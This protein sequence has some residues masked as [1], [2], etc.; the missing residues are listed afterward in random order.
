MERKELSKKV[1]LLSYCNFSN[2]VFI[3]GSLP[4]L[5][6]VNMFGEA[7]LR[8]S[9]APYNRSAKPNRYHHQS[10]SLPSLLPDPRYDNSNTSCPILRHAIII[11]T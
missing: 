3:S 1:F 8:A 2:N 11:K 10:T 6:V 4:T 5:K 7:D 9:S